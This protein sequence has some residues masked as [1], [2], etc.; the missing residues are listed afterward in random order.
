MKLIVPSQGHNHKVK[1][2][3]SNV[4]FPALFESGDKNRR[5]DFN[6]PIPTL[7]IITRLPSPRG[8]SLR[9]RTSAVLPN[10]ATPHSRTQAIS[11]AQKP[12]YGGFPSEFT[13]PLVFRIIHWM[14]ILL[15]H[16]SL[17]RKTSGIILG[18][19]FKRTILCEASIRSYFGKTDPTEEIPHMFGIR[20]LKNGLD[21]QMPSK[22]DLKVEAMSTDK[23]PLLP[24]II[25]CETIFLQM[26][27]FRG[28]LD[29]SIKM[30]YIYIS[31]YFLLPSISATH[32]AWL[33]SSFFHTSYILSFST[34]SMYIIFHTSIENR[35][36]NRVFVKNN[37]HYTEWNI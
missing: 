23:W 15:E 21:L 28:Y 37:M 7:K 27:Y 8:F 22:I 5:F 20:G 17:L 36:F 35:I 31:S 19:V 14:S 26:P 12:T 18:K 4:K 29:L 11:I 1:N 25:L 9:L 13:S 10:V 30:G 3:I 6:P 2:V 34:H 32:P 33:R 24:L 16:F